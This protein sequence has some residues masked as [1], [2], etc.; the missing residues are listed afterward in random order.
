MVEE[1]DNVI[2]EGGSG[3]VVSSMAAYMPPA[4]PKE[5]DHAPAFTPADELPK[6]PFLSAEA[7]PNSMAAYIIS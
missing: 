2:A 1:F 3:L 6:P 5:Q 7:I 4:L